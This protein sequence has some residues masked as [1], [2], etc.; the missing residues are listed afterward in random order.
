[1]FKC[2]ITDVTDGDY[3]KVVN[4]LGRPNE[5]IVNRSYFQHVGFTSIPPEGSIGIIIHEDN[6]LSM[7]AT[8]DP[9]TNRPALT[10]ERDVAVYADANK[11]IKIDVD[12]KIE[13]KNNN[14]TITLKANGDIELGKAALDALVKAAALSPLAIHTHPV[15]GAAAGP[16][17]DPAMAALTTTPGNKTQKVTGQ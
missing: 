2:I 16:S 13:I 4:A 1:M 7:I 5:Q 14:N 10:N 9:A 6:N 11:Y 8:A 17:T 12:G 15:S 3:Q